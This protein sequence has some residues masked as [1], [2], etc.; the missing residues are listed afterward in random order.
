MHVLVS[1]KRDHRLLLRLTDALGAFAAAVHADLEALNTAD[2]S[3]LLDGYRE[4]VDSRHF[5]KERQ[6]LLPTLIRHGCD[7]QEA[8][9]AHLVSEHAQTREL[10][11]ELCRAAKRARCWASAER[12]QVGATVRQL[13]AVQRQ[14]SLHQESQLYPGIVARLPGCVLTDLAERLAAFDEQNECHVRNMSVYSLSLDVLARYGVG[15]V[16]P[17][18]AQYNLRRFDAGVALGSGTRNRHGAALCTSQRQTA[19]WRYRHPE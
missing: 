12:R 8:G 2:L 13:V 14:A 11:G 16:A 15:P 1:L 5:E 17:A 3:A 10:V 18:G 4:F 19:T 7:P 6:I 9:I